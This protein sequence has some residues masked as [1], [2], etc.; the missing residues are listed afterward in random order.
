MPVHFSPAAL[1]QTRWHEYLVRFALGGAA[2]VLTG[3][4]G[5]L[6]GTSVGGLF[7]ALPAIFCASATLIERH[8]R[9][10]KQEAGLK[11][12]RRGRQAAALDAAGA[13]LGSLGLLAFAAEFSVLVPVS[14]LGAFA[15]AL[16]AWAIVSVAMWWL[17][18]KLRVMHHGRDRD[19][20]SSEQTRPSS[21]ATEIR[22]SRPRPGAV[23][24][25][26]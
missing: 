17:R 23:R 1:K 2:T 8:E 25:E 18:R 13:G 22:T 16:A 4:I 6:F 5:S 12:D 21:A 19:A 11:G 3:A 26:P 9:R 24:S 14:A 10:K 7:L 20:G 15:A